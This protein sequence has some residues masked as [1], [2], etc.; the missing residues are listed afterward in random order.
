MAEKMAETLKKSDGDIDQDYG[1]LRRLP[2]FAEKNGEKTLEII[3]SYFLDSKNNLN[4]GCLQ[5][6][7]ACQ[8]NLFFGSDLDGR[9]VPL[10]DATASPSAAVE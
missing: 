6:L 9:F 2:I 8:I 4:H 1:L 7:T 5:A 10:A 3:L